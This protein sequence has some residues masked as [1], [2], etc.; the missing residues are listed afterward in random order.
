VTRIRTESRSILS[1]GLAASLACVLASCGGGSDDSPPAPPL[2]PPEAPAPTKAEAF[3]FLNQASFGATDA[4]AQQVISQKYEAWI[5]AQLA[6]PAS[7]QLPTMI[8]ALQQL[9]QPITN[10]TVLHDNR[11]ASWFQNTVRG[12]D[13][14]RQRVAFALSEVMVVSQNSL[15]EYPLGVADYY[16]TLARG[17]FGN[18]RTLIEDVTLHP[19]MGVYLSMLGNRKPNTGLNIRPDE[20]YAR[21][22]MQLFTV[23]LVQLNPDGSIKRDAQLQPLPTYNQ[24]TIEGFAHVFTGWNWAGAAS[25]NA[26][27]PTLPNQIAPMQAYAGEHDAGAKLVLS[28]PGATLTTI[29]ANQTPAKDLDDALDNIFNHPNVGPF[30]AKHLIQ[31]L[32]TSN[33]TPQYIERIATRFNNDGNG[34]RGNLSAVVKAILLDAEAR[35]VSTSSSAGKL[36]EPLLRLTQI[37]RAFN[38]AAGNGTL[39]LTGA[40]AGTTFFFGQGPLQAGSVFNFFSP[41]YAPPG[42]ISSQ[43]LVAP[44]LQIATEFLN[45]MSASYFFGMAVCYVPTPTQGCA[46]N[47]PSTVILDTAAEMAVAGTPAVLVDKVADRLL[48]GQ[49]SP[50]LRAEALGQVER[51]P[52]SFPTV[53][54]AEAIYLISTS[55]EFARQQ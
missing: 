3:K 39:S 42:E 14:L 46:A 33:P 48:A 23:G 40:Q 41:S 5:D 17:A 32:V 47:E 27:Q 20:N 28:Y 11:V 26:A 51:I 2:P 19:M 55:P 10:I 37:W 18:F 13:Q 54:V 6:L 16:D 7:T 49:I 1:A 4:A 44:E 29:P 43:N 36:K 9:P 8:T 50:T 31:R 15:L 30:I 35:D 53:R 21:E 38:A 24:A 52:S 25:F 34:V 45:A 22:L 12:P